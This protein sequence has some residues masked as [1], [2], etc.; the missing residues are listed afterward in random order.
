MAAKQSLRIG[1]GLTT[2]IAIGAPAAGSPIPG[3]L[4][5]G[6]QE[7]LIEVDAREID[8]DFKT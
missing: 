7:G 2:G 5:F 8:S 6:C 1:S 4:F 3:P